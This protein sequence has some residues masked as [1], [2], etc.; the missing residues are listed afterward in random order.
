MTRSLNQGTHVVVERLEARD[1]GSHQL[2]YSIVS[3]PVPVTDYSSTI[4]LSAS[5][6]AKT[7]IAW[8]STFTPVGISDQDAVAMFEKV[9]GGGIKGLQALFPAT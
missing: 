9:Y 7:H 3:G 6:P 4:A 1:E 8:S 2:S 5:G